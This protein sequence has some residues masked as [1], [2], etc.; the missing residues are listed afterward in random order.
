LLGRESD[1]GALARDVFEQSL[2]RYGPTD[3]RAADAAVVFASVLVQQERF[4]EGE[5]ILRDALEPLRGRRESPA[6]ARALVA[7]ALCARARGAAEESL[8]RFDEGIAESTAV[9]GTAHPE[10]LRAR[11]ERAQTLRARGRAAEA[12]VALTLVAKDAADLPA[13]HWI[14]A[15]VDLARAQCLADLGR[16]DEARALAARCDAS[17]SAAL[18]AEHPLAQ[19]ARSLSAKPA[20]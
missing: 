3:A 12:E 7:L 8:A 2:E 9:L 18:G 11:V 4:D 20:R 14:R 6:L 5:R 13:E 10:T 19:S 1:A 15:A 16:T 17:L